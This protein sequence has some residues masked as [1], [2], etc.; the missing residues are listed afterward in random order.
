[1]RLIYSNQDNKTKSGKH[2]T[3]KEEHISQITIQHTKR[4][5]NTKQVYNTKITVHNKVETK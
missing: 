2:I 1:M 3:L 4:N 5:K